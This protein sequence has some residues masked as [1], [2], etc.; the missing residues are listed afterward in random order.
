MLEIIVVQGFCP[1]KIKI[2]QSPKGFHKCLIWIFLFL[3]QQPQNIRADVTSSR[4]SLHSRSHSVSCSFAVF[5]AD[6][7]L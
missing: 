4:Y 1:L 5:A 2:T 6:Y 7:E 3:M